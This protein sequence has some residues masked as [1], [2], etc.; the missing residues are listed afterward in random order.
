MVAKD[1]RL[2]VTPV[3]G[4][5]LTAFRS[6][7]RT[8]T[9]ASAAATASAALAR[10]RAGRN[11][12]PGAATTPEPVPTATAFNDVFAEESR[13]VLVTFQLPQLGPAGGSSSPPPLTQ[14]A[15]EAGEDAHHEGTSPATAN[16]N[17]QQQEEVVDVA[18]VELEYTDVSSGLQRRETAVLRVRRRPGGRGPG[19]LPAEVVFVTALRF[20]TI[21]AI[22]EAQRLAGQGGGADVAPAHSLLDT[23][24]GRLASAPLQ[25]SHVAVF[26]E[27]TQVARQSIKPRYEVRLIGHAVAC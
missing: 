22:E 2:S 10:G 18:S 17:Q 16:G 4:V 12:P 13:E 14:I 9:S 6:G 27:Q 26:R 11:A 25:T 24:L 3:E 19:V 20:E 21:D 1:V 23:H 7:G 15:E 5:A 8:N